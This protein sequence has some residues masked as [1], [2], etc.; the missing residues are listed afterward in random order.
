MD[1]TSRSQRHPAV[2]DL[3]LR[4]TKDHEVR[5][6]LLATVLTNLANMRHEMLKAVAQNLR[7]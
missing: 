7:S 5:G 3:T 1:K 4:D 6:G 2:K